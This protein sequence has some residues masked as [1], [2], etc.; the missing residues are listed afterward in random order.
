MPDQNRFYSGMLA[1]MLLMMAASGG[2]WF[3]TPMS[4]PNAT[5]LQRNWVI[6]QIVIGPAGAAW[7]IIRGRAGKSAAPAR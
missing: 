5:A 2:N 4:H 1:G 7:L 6:G 3:I